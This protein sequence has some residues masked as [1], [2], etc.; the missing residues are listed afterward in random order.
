MKKIL[1]LIVLAW[2]AGKCTAQ[3]SALEVKKYV[4]D[5]GFTVYL[6]EDRSAKDVYGAVVVN[7]G[8]KN[9]PADATGIA[10]YLEHLLFK[11]TTEMGTTNYE[12]EKPFLDSI[13]MYYDLLG[14]TKDLDER[15]KIQQLINNHSVQASQYALPTEFDKLIKSIGGTG[16]NAFTS[17]DMTVYHNSF[18]GEQIE[19]WLELYSHRFQKPVFRSFQSELE[20]VY[21]EKNRS[22]DSYFNSLFEE[23]NKNQFRYHPYGTQTTLGTIEHLKNPSLN[24]MYNFFNTYYVANNMAL[25]LCGNFDAEKTLSIIREKFSKLKKGNVPVFPQYPK[26]VFKGKE[27]AT[28]KYTPIKMELLSFKSI[29]SKHADKAALEVCASLLANESETGKLNKL[30]RENKIIYAD[31]FNVTYND[32]GS[33]MFL[34][35]PKLIGQ[36]LEDAEKLVLAEVA[37]IRNGDISD[38]DLQIIKTELYRQRQQALENCEDRALNIVQ[39][40]SEGSTWEDYLKYNQE[41]ERVSKADIIRVAKKY[42]SDNYFA[43]YSKKGKLKNKK[44]EKPGFKAVATDQKDESDYAKKIKNIT[45]TPTTPKFLDFEKDAQQATLNESNT[46][47]VTSNPIN[48][49]F[50]LTVVFKVGKNTIKNL[51]VLEFVFNRFTIKNMTID[52]VKKEF[53]LLG[54]TYYAEAT[55]Q[56]FSIRFDGLESNLQQALPLINKLIYES[57]IDQKSATTACNEIVVNRKAMEKEVDVSGSVLFEYVRLGNNSSYMNRFSSK[58]LKNIKADF[59]QNQNN[60]VISYNATWHYVGTQPIDEIKKQLIN[61]V[62]F[63]NNKKEIPYSIANNI[64]TSTNT[65]YLVNDKKAVQ[66]QIYFLV[67]SSNYI[68]SPQLY[69]KMQAFDNY[70]SGDFSGL[71]LQEI[72][73]YRSLAY[74]AWGGDM[75]PKVQN[76]PSYFKSFAGS[77]ADK[78]N[79]TIEVMCNLIKSMPQKPE[80][81]EM[82]SSL[83]KNSASA[84]YPSFR[85]ISTTIEDYKARGYMSNPLKETYNQ[86]ES[87]KFS[88]INSFYEEYLK[89]KPITIAIYGDKSKMDLDKISKYGKV[90]ELKHKDIITR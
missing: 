7:A 43:L 48:N 35:I 8:S 45:I 22:M 64:A 73:E 60:Q 53:A 11:G 90:I 61:N 23:M 82:I 81:I 50:S 62:R 41:I 57:T 44:I 31:C 40:F 69:A 52:S 14:K 85:N 77:Q 2:I 36:S 29:P 49:L 71:I 89:S 67:N 79:E 25:V 37:K 59:L 47:Y 28:V 6:N 75:E 70:M 27:S 66:S 65:V 42:L 24:K 58:Q 32:D 30:Q 55:D 88:D 9:D 19:K 63:S 56:T 4:L 38:T 18:P 3:N 5:N 39:T 54:V 34:V 78:T 86:Y 21:E 76:N 83:L 72:R 74:S 16:L 13:N 46:L 51:D 10:H 20:V 17:E 84:E 12:K 80:R 1:F 26:T 15:K 68:F 87:L 33:I